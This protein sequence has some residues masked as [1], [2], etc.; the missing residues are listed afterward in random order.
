VPETIRVALVNDYA[1]VL[2]GLRALLRPYEPHITVVELEVK[3][4]P[5][6]AVDVTLF[7]TYGELEERRQRVRG[8]A[9]DATNGAVVVFSFSDDAALAGT[10]V[11]AGAQGFIS[12]ALPAEQIVNGIRAAAR[13]ERVMLVQASPH[14]AMAA[15][16]QWPGREARLTERESEVLA[17]LPTGMTNRE[18]GEHLHI[19]ENT[20]KGHLRRL[21]SKLDVRNRAQAAALARTGFLGESRSRTTATDVTEN[22]PDPSNDR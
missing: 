5:Q 4:N 6:S 18:L 16:L 13:G 3:G 7:D 11:R 17:L 21:F 19:S 15:E 12:K 14:A 2:E 1:I 20:I 10:F 22:S 9:T 8:L